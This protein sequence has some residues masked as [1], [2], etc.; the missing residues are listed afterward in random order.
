VIQAPKTVLVVDD[1]PAVR[2]LLHQG[3]PPHLPDHAIATVANGREAIDYLAA[4]PVEVMV[5]DITMPVVDG[6]ELLA[7]VRNHHPN[8]PVVVLASA[9]PGWVAERAPQL[10]AIHVLQKPASPERVARHVLEAI[11]ETVRGRMAG[12]PLSTLLRLMQLERKSCS[13]LVRSGSRKGRLHFLSGELVNAYA[14][15]LA[16]DGE[17]AAR[18]LL[19]LDEVTIDFERSLHNHVR[20]IHTPL[21]TLLLEVAAAL[22][23]ARRDDAAT[24]RSD[25][26]EITRALAEAAERGVHAGPAADPEGPRA[27]GPPVHA[28]E[29]SLAS[30]HETLVGLRARS[31]AVVTLLDASL[32]DL[33]RCTDALRRPHRPSPAA[34]GDEVRM[35]AA[36]REV[37]ALAT[38]LA[39]AADAPGAGSGASDA[40]DPRALPVRRA[41][42]DVGVAATIGPPKG[43]R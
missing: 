41:A 8:L 37:S 13:L 16:T 42:N 1:E 20:R 35:A 29:T 3:L 33:A 12:V 31:Q 25:G 21:E 15:E 38:R 7:H 39:R 22:D 9:A 40:S 23:E 30:L 27:P 43:D 32:L 34:T 14:F 36:W 10:G 18:H 19:M 26:L 4:Y 6:F 2:W 28:L 11:S 24:E 17:V 5:T